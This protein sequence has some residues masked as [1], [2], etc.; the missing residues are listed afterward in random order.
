MLDNYL[1]FSFR[2][3]KPMILETEFLNYKSCYNFYNY[4]SKYDDT[5]LIIQILQLEVWC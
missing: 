3:Q 4:V 1:D 2:K 5:I